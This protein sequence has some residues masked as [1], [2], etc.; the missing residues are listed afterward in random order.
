MAAQHLNG[1]KNISFKFPHRTTQTAFYH[2]Q[3]SII[4]KIEK[5]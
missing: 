2:A 1:D 3:I 5:I 4:K